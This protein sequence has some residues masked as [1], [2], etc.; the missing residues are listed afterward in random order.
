[1]IKVEINL[2]EIPEGLARLHAAMSDM[3]P[4]MQEIGEL[5]VASTKTRFQ[6]GTAPSGAKW[7]AKSPATIAAYLARKERADTRPLFGPSGDLS[8]QIFYDAGPDRVEWGSNM[9]YAAMMH[10]GGSKSA[11]PHLWGDIPARP[12]LGIS[13]DDETGIKATI[14]EWLI[15][16]ADKA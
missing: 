7:A 4:V 14:E 9:I 1:M 13:D 8:R 5:L 10:F 16:I 6:T 2:N 12:F 3:S 15:R 11:Y